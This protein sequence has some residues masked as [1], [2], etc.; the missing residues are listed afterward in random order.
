MNSMPKTI[1]LAT[2][3]SE[4]SALAARAA[5]DLSRKT[6][7]GLHVVHAWHT[8][9]SAY[10]GGEIT[11]VLEEAAEE[12]LSDQTKKIRLLGGEVSGT[13][14]ERRPPSQAILELAT[15][16]NAD[17]IAMGSRGTGR[18]K[19]LATGSVSENVVHHARV[20]V[21]MLRG[22]ENA[23]PP[24]RIV[25]GMDGSEPAREAAALAAEIGR[26]CGAC[27]TL[28]RVYP[29]LPEMYEEG[30]KMN[31]RITDDEL[32]RAEKEL[33]SVAGEVEAVLGS[34][35]RISIAVGDAAES[36]VETGQKDDTRSTLIALGSRGL[37]PL[38]RLRMGSVS[39]KVLRAA[40]GPVLIKPSLPGEGVRD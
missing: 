34:R 25:S 8:I 17:L 37:R 27:M 24:G 1:L 16:L 21:L 39:T 33:G 6:G 35:P 7:A 31:P 28:V 10:Y 36:L 18:L 40:D 38:K 23:W 14:L 20:P 11:E 32:S 4:D 3:G 26:L 13:Y 30:R 29:E 22:G 2:D 9:P 15:E 12:I 5:A 19:K